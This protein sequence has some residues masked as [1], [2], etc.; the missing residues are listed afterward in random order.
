MGSGDASPELEA[1]A[2]LLGELIA[3]EGW[4]LLTGGRDAGVM[5][6]A[7]RGAKKIQGSIV[8]GVLPTAESTPAPSVDVAIVTNMHDARNAIN[9]LSSNVVVACGAGSGTASEVALAIKAGK[10]VFLLAQ[11]DAAYAFYHELAPDRVVRA[12]SPRQ[13]IEAIRPIAGRFAS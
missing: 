2:E 5:R 11:T 6:A 1:V 13:V 8:V 3:G 12:E 9:V 4:V 7:G 10:T